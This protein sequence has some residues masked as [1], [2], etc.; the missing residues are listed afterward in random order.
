MAKTVKQVIRQDPE[1]LNKKELLEWKRCNVLD[2]FS[3]V[4]ANSDIVIQ[5]L[6][7]HGITVNC[8]VEPASNTIN[9]MQ[10]DNTK[11][12]IFNA[13]FSNGDK[14]E[15]RIIP[16]IVRVPRG[17]TIDKYNKRI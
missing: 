4:I 7:E 11:H 13:I 3:T 12:S 9:L 6:K 17:T 1:T 2:F 5:A 14:E 16:A 10:D 8:K 15:A